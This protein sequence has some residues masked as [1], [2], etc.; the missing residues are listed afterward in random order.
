MW[1]MA[2]YENI[3]YL[4]MVIFFVDFLVMHTYGF[5][6]WSLMNKKQK[7]GEEDVSKNE[8]I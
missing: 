5:V 7:S 6:K 8:K 1:G 2:S 3:M 4:P